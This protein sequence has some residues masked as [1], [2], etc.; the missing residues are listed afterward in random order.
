MPPDPYEQLADVIPPG[1]AVKPSP[2]VMRSTLETMVNS[3]NVTRDQITQY[4]SD[5]GSDPAVARG[6]DTALA[7]RDHGYRLHIP[8]SLLQ[9]HQA[10]EPAQ[11]TDDPYA[12]LADTVHEQDVPQVTA[13]L[14]RPDSAFGSGV[15]SFAN[16]LTAGI[17]DKAAA[18][19]DTLIPGGGQPTVWNGHSLADAY[20]ANRDTEKAQ[21]VVDQQAHGP[22]SLV[23]DIAGTIASPVNKIAAPVEGA[24]FVSNLLRVGAAGATYG[25]VRGATESNADGLLA[26]GSDAAK[27]SLEYGAG[28]MALGAVLAPVAGYASKLISAGART[29]RGNPAA[30]AGARL[31]ALRMAQDGLTPSDALKVVSS[32]QSEGTP[33]MLSDAGDNLR[34]LAGSVSRQPG[35]AR[36]IAMDATLERQTGQTGRVRDAI[37]RDLGPTTDTLAE[38]QKLMDAARS[39]AGPLYEQ[40]YASQLEMTPDL[41]ATLSTPAGKQALARARTLALNEGRNPDQLGFVLNGDGDVTV[42]DAGR[43]VDARGPKPPH[44]HANE[45]TVADASQ[46]AGPDQPFMP[47]EAMG[48]MQAIAPTVQTMDYVKR[49][50]DDII[51]SAPRDPR[52]NLI[53]DEHLRSV[54][55]VKNRLLAAVDGQAP[56]YAHARAAYA[57]PAHLAE[58]MNDGRKAINKSANEINQ[59]IAGM[60]TSEREQYALGLRSAIADAIDKA[61]DG[62]NIARRVIGSPAKREALAKAFGDKGEVDRLIATLRNEQATHRTYAA[63]HGGSVSANRLAEDAATNGDLAQVN[64]GLELL[65]AARH[66]KTGIA[67]LIGRKV[68]DAWTYGAGQVGQR[69]REDAASLLFAPSPDAFMDEL[70]LSNAQRL[71]GRQRFDA[72][73]RH[74]LKAANRIGTATGVIIHR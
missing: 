60:T 52:G 40:A 9:P 74:A 14:V 8:V 34:S 58:V 66:G 70:N 31:I 46:P 10:A 27:T 13:K 7:A 6:L 43:Y 72:S 1:A 51:Q 38:H 25:A 12:G 48:S 44:W 29:V 65:N 69:T 17:A 56:T 32:A 26:V 11:H 28:G 61:L 71:L 22:A 73:T 57:G 42:S 30:G 19:A 50:L 45:G 47:P 59:R 55:G 64:Q 37:N 15:R 68:G 24:G 54:Q 53:M 33:M 49:G 35:P 2:E 16:G 5:S 63:V 4:L 67:S 36:T 20:A 39:K 62:A 41:H 23:G 3:R 21:S 18:V